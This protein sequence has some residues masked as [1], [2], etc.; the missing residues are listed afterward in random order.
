[1]NNIPGTPIPASPITGSLDATT[2]DDVFSIDLDVGDSVSLSLAVEDESAEFVLVVYPPDATDV[3]SG[4]PTALN[5]TLD[6]PLS[7]DIV[8][9]ESGTFFIDVYR[10]S[11]D[12]AIGYTLTYTVVGGSP[13]P[14]ESWLLTWDNLTGYDDWDNV[15]IEYLIYD[16]T[17]TPTLIAT[18]PYP[19]T[20][21]VI[22]EN[23]SEASTFSIAVRVDNFEWAS[24]ACT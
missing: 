16:T 7:L 1:M 11:G 22:T 15:D 17:T 21:V 18:V 12:T 9:A 10:P 23:V 6:Y 14:S 19:A 5:D 8:V 13:A 20:S 3:T 4:V 2:M 24:V